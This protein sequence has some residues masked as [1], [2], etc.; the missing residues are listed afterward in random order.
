MSETG[1][2]RV[3]LLDDH[4][5]IRRGVERL[6]TAAPGVAVVGE[7]ANRGEA[8]ARVPR[9]DPDVAIVDIRVPDGSGVEICRELRSH[10]PSLACL[11]LTPFAE[12]EALFE[13]VM[14]GAAGWEPKVVRGEELVAAV[15]EVAEGHSLLDHGAVVTLLD[16]L[17]GGGT[18]RQGV[19]AREQGLDALTDDDHRTL[20]LIGEGLTDRQIAERLGVPERKVRTRVRSVLV[21]L[22]TQRR[23]RTAVPSGPNAG[24]HP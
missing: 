15:R 6:L 1:Q 14:A 7:A 16:R 10:D 8:L 18:R 4:E 22:G 3:F 19:T 9:A 5:V 17:H 21:K 23:S 12:D 13:A 2:I 20:E 24:A 11:M